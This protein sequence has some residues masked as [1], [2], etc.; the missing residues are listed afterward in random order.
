[1]FKYKV[2]ILPKK[3]IINPES[4]QVLL[5]S[6][7]ISNISSLKIGKYIEIES[8][9]EDYYNIDMLCKNLL[10]NTITESY[11]IVKIDE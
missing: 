1:M 5:L 6:K 2:Y 9:Q 3:S 8:E 11:S 4:E 10:A 7:K